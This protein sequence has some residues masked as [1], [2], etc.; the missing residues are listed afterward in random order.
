M[1]SAAIIISEP[2]MSEA[3]STWKSRERRRSAAGP[4][5]ASTQ[6]THPVVLRVPEKLLNDLDAAVEQRSVRIPRHTWLLEAIAEKLER[7]QASRGR[8]HGT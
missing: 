6:P 3:R 4:S 7:E 5:K 8:R 1:K 2:R